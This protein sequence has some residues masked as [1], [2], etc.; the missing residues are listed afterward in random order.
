[1]L[2]ANKYY[3]RNMSLDNTQ[4]RLVAYGLENAVSLDYDYKEKYVYFTDTGKQRIYRLKW[5]QG[6]YDALFTLHRNLTTYML[7]L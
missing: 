5:E 7:K 3:I 4:S 2:I 1:M 6:V